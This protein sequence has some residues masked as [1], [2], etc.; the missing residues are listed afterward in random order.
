MG[1]L[2]WIT[3]GTLIPAMLEETEL[4]GNSIGYFRQRKVFFRKRPHFCSQDV[5]I[6]VDFQFFNNTMQNSRAVVRHALPY[7]QWRMAH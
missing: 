1:E 6:L 3:N 7:V 4:L 2:S 5:K